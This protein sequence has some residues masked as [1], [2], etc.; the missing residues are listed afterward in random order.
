MEVVITM[1]TND[2]ARPISGRGTV[3]MIE[4]TTSTVWPG[5]TRRAG[6][7]DVFVAG[8]HLI[9]TSRFP[10]RDAAR[11][12]LRWGFAAN[13]PLTIGRRPDLPNDWTTSLGEA[14]Q[15]LNSENVVLFAPPQKRSPGRRIN[16]TH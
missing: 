3:I 4:P 2:P 16:R 1:A 12:L 15:D 5:K 6:F 13:M 11:E 8:R 14:A 10:V 9:C 7:F